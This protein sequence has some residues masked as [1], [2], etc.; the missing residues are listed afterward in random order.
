M[1]RPHSNQPAPT[2]LDEALLMGDLAQGE[3]VLVRH[4]QQVMSSV[5]PARPRSGDAELSAL[6]REQAELVGRALADAP[7][8]A[9]WS[10]GLRRADATAAAIAGHHGL[11]VQLD[12][13]L[14]EVRIYSQV[15]PGTTVA[16]AIGQDGLEDLRRRFV[17]AP[18][19]DEFPLSE[20]SDEI[21][22]RAMAVLTDIAAASAGLTVIVCHSGLMNT[23]VSRIFRTDLDAVFYAY[24]A[25]MTWLAHGEGRFAV[26]SLNEHHHLAPDHVTW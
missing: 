7:V 12:E 10:S 23:M 21:S 25:S 19:W 15:P 24:H 11:D 4:A 6:G 3:I 26:R 13:R 22:T 8:S 16:E 1:I 5:D 20:S 17:A 9:V 14:T 2:V 18:R